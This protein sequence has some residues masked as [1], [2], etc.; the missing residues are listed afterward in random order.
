M[1]APAAAG[2]LL[3]EP[4]LLAK[5]GTE[6]FPVAMRL[7]PRSRR[8]ELLAIY[9]FARLVDDLGDELPGGP[10]V[11]LAALERAEAELDRAFAG[12]A[13]DP[14]FVRLTPVIE[15][16]SLERR[17]FADLLAANRLD[18]EKACRETYEELLDYCRLSANPVGR[19]VLALA[20]LAGE[21]AAARLSDD[22]CTG[23]QIV[24]HLQDVVEDAARGRVYLPAEDMRAFGVEP[25]DLAGE[26]RAGRGAASPA[27][28]RLVAFETGRAR[29]LLASA[30]ELAA[31]LPGLWRLVVAGYG[32]GGLAQAEALELA[33]YDVC[34]AP[35]ALK[36]SKAR[37]ARCTARV[38]LR[39]GRC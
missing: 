8:E 23:L 7:L 14:V 21:Q 6:N 31:R 22:V 10:Q 20:G 28:R 1:T 35:A 13:T 32:G 17:P 9:G 11:R 5:A 12:A 3:D 36:A 39:K 34:S 29:E 16:R 24:E 37:V 25:G 4:A 38:L 30:G 26:T 2:R 27:L 33:G 19:L 15:R 18:Q